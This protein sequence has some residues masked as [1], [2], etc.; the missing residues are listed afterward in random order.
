V[1]LSFQGRLTANRARIEELEKITETAR[2]NNSQTEHM[3]ERQREE[4][5]KRRK[6]AA[7][8]QAKVVDMQQDKSELQVCLIN[9]FGFN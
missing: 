8:S 3:L 9:G 4:L 2:A 5:D 6:E 1:Q 7:Q